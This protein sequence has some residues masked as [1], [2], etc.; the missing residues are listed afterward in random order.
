M[1][2]FESLWIYLKDRVMEEKRESMHKGN[3]LSTGLLPNGNNSCDR[4]KPRTE[5][6]SQELHEGLPC[7]PACGPSPAALLDALS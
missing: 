4:A 7:A 5:A 1:Y 3:F 6:W 2:L